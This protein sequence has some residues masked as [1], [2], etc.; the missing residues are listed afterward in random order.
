MFAYITIGVDY[1]IVQV[2]L[3]YAATIKSDDV[4]NVSVSFSAEDHNAIVGY[5]D[6]NY[7]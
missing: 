7:F 1:V 2:L 5:F 6:N 3:Q 4:I